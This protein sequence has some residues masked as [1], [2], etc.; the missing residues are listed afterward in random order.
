[1]LY[2]YIDQ[3]E[4]KINPLNIKY[5]G[6][7]SQITFES[8]RN[9]KISIILGIGDNFIRK[10]LF[11]MYELE[12]IELIN[13]ID[14]TANL[15]TH[16]QIG[17]ANYFAKNTIIN[18]FVSIQN[19]CIFNSGCI[20][21]HECDIASHVHIAPGAVLC[22]NVTVGECSFIGANSVV[23]QGVKIGKNVTIGA[24]S[25]VLRNVPNNEVWIGNPAKK[26]ANGQ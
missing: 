23:K 8:L 9:D 22:G 11:L 25:V 1:M 3:Q 21:E 18:S 12:K 20:V 17:S 15:S 6:N 24:G 14:K 2:G 10:R 16:V 13:V 7:E 4:K 5:I 19:N 26:I